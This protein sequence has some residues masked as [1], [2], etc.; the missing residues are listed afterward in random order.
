MC[1]PLV[2]ASIRRS[3]EIS[4]GARPGGREVLRILVILIGLPVR[5][6]KTS[7]IERLRCPVN[8]RAEG[9]GV[10]I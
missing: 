9:I 10:A 7:R 4:W 3:R 2:I 6:D 5:V 1:V 8:W